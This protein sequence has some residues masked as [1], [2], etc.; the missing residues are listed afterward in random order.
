LLCNRTRRKPRKETRI[1][2]GPA[3]LPRREEPPEPT[4]R[5][6]QT[7]NHR[8]WGGADTKRDRPDCRRCPLTTVQT[9]RTRQWRRSQPPSKRGTS[10]RTQAQSV[11]TA[12]ASPATPEGTKRA[13]PREPRLPGRTSSPPPPSKM[14]PDS[15]AAVKGGVGTAAN[16]FDAAALPP[17]KRRRRKT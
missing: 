16:L 17:T 7:R 3:P 11:A 9:Y 2:P 10:P 14:R 4:S 15:N 8:G 1:S 6:A 13:V 5:L 12:G